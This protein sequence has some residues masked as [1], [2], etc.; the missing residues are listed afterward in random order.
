MARIPSP[1]H[2]SRRRGGLRGHPGHDVGHEARRGQRVRQP[3]EVLLHQPVLLHDGGTEGALGGVVQGGAFARFQLGEEHLE[4]GTLLLAHVGSS[5][6]IFLRSFSRA[7]N[8]RAMMV[9]GAQP[10]ICAISFVVRF[11]T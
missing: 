3:E 8:R 7:R 10:R 2:S 4:V 6:V 11:W 9:P 5:V 1:V